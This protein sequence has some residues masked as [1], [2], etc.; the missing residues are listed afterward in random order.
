V[1]EIRSIDPTGRMD[2]RYYNPRPINVA[3]AEASKKDGTKKVFIVLQDKGYP[4]ATYKLNYL[5]KE[6]VL[7][8]S[9]FQ[10]TA[11]QTFSVVFVSMK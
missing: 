3:H 9:Y 5:P 2:A 6:N 11:A 4:G 8:G 7:A 10:P 1:L